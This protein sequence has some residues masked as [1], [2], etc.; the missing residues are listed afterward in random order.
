LIIYAVGSYTVLQ[1]KK[2]KKQ[3]N[4]FVGYSVCSNNCKASKHW[5]RLS[6]LLMTRSV[7]K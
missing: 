4:T 1:M 3:S 5:A 7:K 6:D 2:A